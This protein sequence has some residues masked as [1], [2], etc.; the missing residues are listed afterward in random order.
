MTATDSAHP[1]DLRRT[2]IIAALTAGILFFPLWMVL[3]R[4]PPFIVWNGRIDPPNPEMNGSIV[5][6]WDIKSVRSCQP[7]SSATVTRVIVDSKGVAHTYAP[8]HAI[9]GTPEQ[10]EPDEI[11]RRIPLPENITGHAKYS[12]VACYA[13]NPIQE[14]APAWMNLP[15]CIQMPEIDFEISDPRGNP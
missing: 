5:V 12:S 4:E 10:R 15:I 2:R 1:R 11:K 9:Y 3:D 13:C 8:V 6:T 7:S 14:Y